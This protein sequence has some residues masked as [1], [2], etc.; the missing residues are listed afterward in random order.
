M[1]EPKIIFNLE[2]V[3]I[4]EIMEQIHGNMRARGYDMEELKR[5]SGGLRVPRAASPSAP[6]SMSAS[7]ASAGG[8]AHVQYWWPIP[9]QKG[10]KGRLRVL[11]NKVMRKL[12]F[13]YLKH[14]FDQQNQFNG[15]AS[16]A[17][18]DMAAAVD[19]LTAENQEL[20]SR[21]SILQDDNLSFQNALQRAKMEME[22]AAE[23]AESQLKA[24]EEVYAA[25]QNALDTIHTAMTARL[26]RIEHELA[27][28][29]GESAPSLPEDPG[30]KLLPVLA[31][32][33]E[34]P[35]SGGA[36][37]YPKI[38]PEA[39]AFDYYLFESKHRGET[40][41]IRKRQERYLP[42]FEGQDNVL[43]LGCGRGEFLQLL[44]EK[45]IS[46]LGVDLQPENIQACARAGVR[47]ELRD[48]IAYLKQC[49]DESLG[50]IFS[51]QVIEHLEPEQLSLLVH[52]AYQKLR[53]GAAMVLETL[54][55]RCLMIFAEC[56][57]L[58]P[59]HSK[60]VHPLTLQFMAECEGFSSLELLSLSPS[61]PSLRFPH[62][63]DH[64]EAD[65]SIDEINR[66]LFGGREYALA[67]RK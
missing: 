60:P 18:A 52:L 39:P 62:L 29:R 26:G 13:F 49:E 23:R 16:G 33:K 56:F 6:G 22:A 38:L 61:D 54:D 9:P 11:M 42:Y 28:R 10:I 1:A 12:T 63:A 65:R 55:P 15:A 32:K 31:E 46:A 3:N 40:G 27:Q 35:E 7:A 8:V 58:D 19:T 43:D 14:T 20:R 64:P 50:G 4:T 36:S 5:L 53:P 57:Y 45:G 51:A 66:L 41:E 48:G 47:A 25:R 59:S 21:V 2:D 17:L 67:A 44:G 30:E 34:P 24:V 37:S